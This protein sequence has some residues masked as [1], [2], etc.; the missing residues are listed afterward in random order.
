MAT[1]THYIGT[2]SSSDGKKVHAYT[3]AGTR[4]S[5]A[6]HVRWPCAKSK[7]AAVVCDGSLGASPQLLPHSDTI[8][9]ASA[10]H[11]NLPEQRRQKKCTHIRIHAHTYTCRPTHLCC[12]A[13]E[14][15]LSKSRNARSSGERASSG[16]VSSAHSHDSSS[17][18]RLQH[19]TQRQS[20][21]LGWLIPS[22]M[23]TG[24]TCNQPVGILV[25]HG[26]AAH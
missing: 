2:S 9:I 5:A 23:V 11:C 8:A 7:N 14:M 20:V 4:T 19:A 6:V 24:P 22:K 26:I 13:R 1:S 17:P 15:A 16:R 25:T 21:H 12:C 18:R 10:L 3:P